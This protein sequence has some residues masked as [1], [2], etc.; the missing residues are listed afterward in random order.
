[1]EHYLLIK[2]EGFKQQELLT[3][4]IKKNICLKNVKV[5][6][7]IELTLKVKGDDFARIK[8]IT[9][10]KYR[11]TVLKESGYI[12]ILSAMLSN[13][14]R[15]CGF[16]LFL[17]IIYFQTLFI[18]EI[19]VEGYEAFTEREVRQALK[20]A[21]MVEGCSKNLDLDK[22]RL[23]LYDKLGNVS[24]VG[25]R[26]KGSMAVVQISE[27]TINPT[28]VDKSKPCNIIANKEGYIYNIIPIEGIRILDTGHYVNVGD[29]VIS[30]LVPIKS[31]AYGQPES[32][33]TERLVHAE[34]KVV[35]RV[36]YRF[37]FNQ[38][39]VEIMKTHTG[40]AFYGI[41]LQVGK[42]AMNTLEIYNPYEVSEVKQIKSINT[43]RPFPIQI[44]LSKVSEV[45]LSSRERTKEEIEK[46]VNKLVRKE[47]KEKLP[48]NAQILNKSLYFTKEKNIIEVS[49]MI[50]SLQEIGI[51]QEIVFGNQTE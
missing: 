34:G 45:T 50:E 47:I 16:I 11:I 17:A 5:H 42:K 22:V 15:I 29:I 1:M 32:A 33:L 23:E 21:G 51:E 43:L 20:E 46:E 28:F 49:V 12:P 25:I 41:E 3:E 48:E 8:G 14:A 31:T 19:R 30:G 4:C 44:S 2:V 24:W 10:N 38:S 13:K 7:N 40:K 18:S 36:P 6:N 39:P 35:A 27:G 26:Q 37:V 9:K